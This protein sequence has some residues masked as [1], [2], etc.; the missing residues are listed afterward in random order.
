MCCRWLALVWV[1]LALAPALAA[2]RAIEVRDDVS[3]RAALKSVRPGT[4]VRIAP[5][6]YRPGVWA[7]NLRGTIQKPIIIRIGWQ[8]AMLAHNIL[9]LG[10]FVILGIAFVFGLPF[11]IVWPVLFVLP[12]GVFQVWMMNRIGEGAKPNWNLLVLVALSS[13]GLTTY[14]LTFAFW[15]N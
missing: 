15:I 10:S 12:V 7:A 5:G 8:A 13:F 4:H 2:E 1:L 9:V 3:L 11:R 6:R 14:I